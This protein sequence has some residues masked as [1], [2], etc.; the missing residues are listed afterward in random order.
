MTQAQAE[1][2]KASDVGSILRDETR[3][4]RLTGTNIKTPHE[5]RARIEEFQNSAFILSP[6]T[7]IA[8]IAPGYE[9]TPVVVVIDPSVDAESGRGADVYFQRSIHKSKKVGDNWVPTEVSLNAAALGRVLAAV[10]VNLYPSRWQHDGVAEKFLW[11]VETDGDL[12]EFDGR[13]RRLPAGVGSL[14][15]RDGS[16]DIGEWTSEE[17]AK[18]VAIAEQQKKAAPEK[19]RWKIK[20]EPLP[21]GWTYE[22]VMGVRKFGRQLALTKSLNSLSYRLGVRH[23]YSVE[24]L[25]KK[26]FVIMRPMFIPD[27]SDSAVRQMVTAANL[28]ARATMYPGSAP[29]QLPSTTDAAIT[30]SHGEPPLDGHVVE[31][32]Q[33][34]EE[35]MV[36][37]APPQDATELIDE[38]A[39]TQQT[40]PAGSV[41]VVTRVLKNKEGQYFVETK[42]GVT[43]FFTEESMLKPVQ[44]AAKD[45][46]PREFSTERVMVKEQPY[47]QIV[48]MTAPGGEKY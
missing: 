23:V 41:Y 1:L 45:G 30:H 48:E 20:P 16:P 34:A 9:I 4:A 39:K 40:P 32:E 6:M 5:L 3:M 14:D 35:R 21:G 33:E 10:G 27:M 18:R 8:S 44:A 37:A 13:V 11:V 42:E 26:P 28:G 25:K 47:R 22:R 24:E 2:V 31:P 17:W 12:I 43:L 36:T 19:E 29:Q 7:A 46:Q 38:P 15:A